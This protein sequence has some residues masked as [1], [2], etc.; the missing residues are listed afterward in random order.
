M[1]DREPER[2]ATARRAPPTG[3][4]LPGAFHVLVD[5]VSYPAELSDLSTAGLQARLDAMTFD[6][7]RE[8][9]DGVR[10]GTRPPLA[11]RLQWG[12][13]DGTFGAAFRDRLAAAPVVEEIIAGFDGEPS[14]AT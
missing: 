13:F 6:E 14:D 9:I 10:F 8:R 12:F 4:A 7:I 1:T 5:E 11:I 2:R 3:M